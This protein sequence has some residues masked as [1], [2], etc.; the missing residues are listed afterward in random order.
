LDI[1]PTSCPNP[2]NTN[3][4]GVLP[5]AILGTA[6]FDVTTIDP[7]TITLAG[8]APLRSNIDD[9]GT[10]FEGE[11]CDCHEQGA[12]GFDDLTLKFSTH[13]IVRAV[14]S[15][16][17][18][19]RIADGT[20]APPSSDGTLASPSSEYLVLTITG[21]LLDGTPFV[22]SDCVRIMHKTNGPRGGGDPSDPGVISETIKEISLGHSY[23]NPF[24]SETRITFSLPKQTH[25]SLIVYDVAGRRVKTLM[26]EDMPGGHHSAG[27]NRTDDA[28]RQLPAGVYFVRMSA[29][30]FDKITKLIVAQ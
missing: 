13:D 12:D 29:Q 14:N 16:S 5:V 8:V 9:V 20:L 7:A 27:W 1:K 30:G 22:G 23:P 21:N 11:L 2:L 18:D 6:D 25:V 24:T 15:V 28:G 19:T 17:V 3:S 10:P 4:M 26:N